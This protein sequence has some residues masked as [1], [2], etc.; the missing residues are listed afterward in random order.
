MR[1][2]G[3]KLR[4]PSFSFCVGAPIVAS[5]CS[6]EL[7]LWAPSGMSSIQGLRAGQGGWGT[8]LK[9]AHITSNCAFCQARAGE[10]HILEA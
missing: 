5:S 8:F 6:H 7:L 2:I 4:V 10:S 1:W 3:G 9:E